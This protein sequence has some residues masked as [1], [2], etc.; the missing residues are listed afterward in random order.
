MSARVRIY[1]FLSIRIIHVVW[2]ELHGYLVYAR[3]HYEYTS[4]LLGTEKKRR[5]KAC[6]ICMFD[7][8][9]A[10]VSYLL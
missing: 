1:S 10:A 5:E 2:L 3:I 6:K 8:V 4:Q 7:S 9:Y